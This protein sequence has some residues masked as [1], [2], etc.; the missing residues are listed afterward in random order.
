MDPLCDEAYVGLS[1]ALLEN[2]DTDEAQSAVKTALH[3]A[4]D[5]IDALVH[6]A[7]VREKMHEPVIAI[8]CYERAL[9]VDPANVEAL[10]RCGV[11]QHDAGNTT[12]GVEY[13]KRAL[14]WNRSSAD[15]QYHLAMMLISDG[16]ISAGM[17][18]VRD[19][20]DSQPEAT[21]RFISI[22]LAL[23]RLKCSD[24]AIE[25]YRKITEL[26]PECAEAF[27]HMGR[28]AYEAGLL[29]LSMEVQETLEQNST[30]YSRMLRL[31]REQSLPAVDITYVDDAGANGS[32]LVSAEAEANA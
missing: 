10:I 31:Y 23:E 26:N 13:L 18:H 12:E 27:Y 4:P 11:L 32:E 3:C 19:L 20:F 15:A 30:E 2:G 8:Q 29:K 24:K 6:Y 22:G 17:I 28:I 5:N 21:R 1:K 14:E 9:R 16:R 7:F 25:V